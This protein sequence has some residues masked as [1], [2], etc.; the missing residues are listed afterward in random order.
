MLV[1]WCPDKMDNRTLE[2]MN[3]KFIAYWAR[4]GRGPGWKQITKDTNASRP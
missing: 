4:L 2:D 1:N 3:A